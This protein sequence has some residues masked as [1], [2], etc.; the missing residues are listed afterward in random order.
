MDFLAKDLSEWEMT[1]P[2]SHHSK[3]CARLLPSM[4]LLLPSVEWHDPGLQSNP[5]EG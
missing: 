1:L 4:T 3:L 5:D 2:S